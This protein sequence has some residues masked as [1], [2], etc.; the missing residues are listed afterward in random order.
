MPLP[1]QAQ[2]K[3]AAESAGTVVATAFAIFGLQA[4]GISLDQIKA[5]IGALGA[6]V[7]D[8]VVLASLLYPVYTSIKGYLAASGKGQAEAIGANPKALVNAA[9]NGKAIITITDP[10]M[11]TAALEG[12]RKAA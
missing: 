5:A 8:L 7:N 6:T 1:T 12:Q 2:V 4:K 10:A 9:P 11:A 3:S